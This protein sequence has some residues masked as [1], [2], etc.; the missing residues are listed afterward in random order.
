MKR[1]HSLPLSA[2]SQRIAVSVVVGI[3]VLSFAGPSLAQ[4]TA[5]ALGM[6]LAYTAL[7]RGVHASDWNPAN[8]GLSNNPSFGMSIFSVGVGVGNNSI[9]INTYNDY[10]TDPYWDSNEINELLN[11][12]PDDGL[13]VNALADV[14]VLSFS[15]G[16]FALSLGVKAGASAFVDKAVLEIPLTGTKIGDTYNFEKINASTLSMGMVKFSYGSPVRVSFTDSF[17][18]GGSFHLDFGGGYS[19]LDTS[20][21]SLEIGSFG[22]NIDGNYAGKTAAF[23]TGWGID[24]GAAAKLDR[25]WTV[26]AGLFNLLGSV[27]WNREVKNIGGYVRS[28]SVSVSDLL[29]DD[30]DEG[31]NTAVQDS[32]WELKGKPFSRKTPIELHIGGLYEE[33]PYALTLDYVQGF[34]NQGWV[35]TKPRLAF[36]TE[37]RKVRWLPLR[38]GVVMGGRIGFGT[39]FGFGIRPGKFVFDFGVLNR[40]FI[41]PNSSKGVFLAVE[42]GVG[43]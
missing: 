33:G 14:R 19:R 20:R 37:W 24:L 2:G 17:A 23:G 43:L 27:R 30:D 21:M 16:R 25:H 35:T 8:L 34:H 32:T 3:S 5:R 7:A 22:L 18:V 15:V 39:S 26:S 6:G 41:L 36:G 38:I 13:G 42:M 28:D 40:G 1:F 9:S 29:E 11:K 4:L 12:I 10:A 31:E